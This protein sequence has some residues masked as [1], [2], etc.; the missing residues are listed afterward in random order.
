MS[1]VFEG[2]VII[3][4]LT[5]YFGFVVDANEAATGAQIHAVVGDPNGALSAPIGSLALSD[6]GN[7][8]QN[9]DGATTWLTVTAA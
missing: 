5:G 2:N 3:K 7:T 8:Y 1:T 9:S 4:T 6:D